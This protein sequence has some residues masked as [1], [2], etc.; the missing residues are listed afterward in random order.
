MKTLMLLLIACLLAGCASLPRLNTASGR[1]EITICGVSKKALMDRIVAGSVKSGYTIASINNYQVATTKPISSSS[2]YDPTPENRLTWTLSDNEAGCT[3]IDIMMQVA[4]NP[5]TASER[6]IEW[7]GGKAA[8]ELQGSL[9][10][11][12][13]KLD[14]AKQTAAATP[15]VEQS[16]K[17]VVVAPPPRAKMRNQEIINVP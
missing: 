8:E 11:L 1:P 16:V 6:I 10:K 17:P 3:H 4:I 2:K 5:G 13:A 7:T 12:K 15:K 14:L 9:V